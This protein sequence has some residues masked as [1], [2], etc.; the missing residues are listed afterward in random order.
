MNKLLTRI[1]KAVGGIVGTLYQAGRDTIDQVIKN[2][3][4]FMAFIAFLIGVIIETGIGDWLANVLSPLAN[5]VIGLPVLSVITP[6][7]AVAPARARCG[8][9]PGDGVLLG[10]DRHG[11]HPPTM[12]LPALWAINRR[13]CDFIPVGWPSAKR[14]PRPSKWAFPPYCSAGW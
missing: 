9:R 4:P 13:G 6:A 2:I 10:P 3:L 12:A 8:D 14:N 5:N 7:G 11:Q 1:G